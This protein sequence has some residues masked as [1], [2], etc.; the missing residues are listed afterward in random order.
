MSGGNGIA[1][2][3][4][5][6]ALPACAVW[7][8]GG[9]RPSPEA[10]P[11]EVLAS[12][13]EELRRSEESDPPDPG[14]ARS[15]RKTLEALLDRSLDPAERETAEFLHARAVHACGSP[16]KAYRQLVQFLERYRFSPHLGEVE[17][18]LFR[19][20][21]AYASSDD[22]FLGLGW[23][24]KRSKAIP[25]LRTLTENFPNGDTA[26]DAL[27][28]L[29]GLDFDRERWAEARA[30]YD[31]LLKNH[32]TSEW[33]DL[34]EYRR[35]LTYLREARR[36]D[37]DRRGLLRAREALEKYLQGRPEG[38]RREE[39]TRVLAEVRAMLAARELEI[40]R[41]YQKIEKWD[42]ARRS[43]RNV[44]AEYPETPSAPFAQAALAG[45][46]PEGP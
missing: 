23:F 22:S 38:M 42:G 44:L 13:R 40:G 34:A 6:L 5:L 33:A 30:A 20:G 41:F 28:L 12:A 26:P 37:L 19:I 7:P 11:Q 1:S 32:A 8:F 2:L 46:P 15:A 3:L 31:Q 35:A 14:L 43:Y 10:T 25:V 18:L 17:R 39:A 45:L 29:G 24:P 9:G 16:W 21:E 4:V 27:R 36:Y